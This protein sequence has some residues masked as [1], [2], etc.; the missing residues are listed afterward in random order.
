MLDERGDPAF[1]GLRVLAS[2]EGDLICEPG[3]A[4]SHGA[5]AC[6][7]RE[8]SG[9]SIIHAPRRVSSAAVPCRPAAW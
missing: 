7:I 3:C 4:A 6:Q 9:S 2:G 5:G 8:A 1:D